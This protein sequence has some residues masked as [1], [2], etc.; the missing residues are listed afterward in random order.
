MRL[1]TVVA[2]TDFST[3]AEHAVDRAAQLAAAHQARLHL[4][5]A[6]I[7]SSWQIPFVERLLEQGI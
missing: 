2:L 6:A 1:H 3:A 7:Q 5:Y 4:L